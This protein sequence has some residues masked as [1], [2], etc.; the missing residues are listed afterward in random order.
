MR[1][2]KTAG[3]RD[4]NDI[5]RAELF[6]IDLYEQYCA[7]DGVQYIVEQSL[8]EDIVDDIQRSAD[9]LYLIHTEEYERHNLEEPLFEILNIAKDLK[10]IEKMTA[11]IVDEYIT[12]ELSDVSDYLCE[13]AGTIIRTII[14]RIVESI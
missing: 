7:L 4:G 13:T 2:D 12:Q 9:L 10:K 1:H 3:R 5:E 6:C 8:N 14:G 11:G